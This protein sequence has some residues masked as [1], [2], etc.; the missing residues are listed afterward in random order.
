MQ[1]DVDVS[2]AALGRKFVK[3]FKSLR[4][5]QIF[6]R[7]Q[8]PTDGSSATAPVRL[9]SLMTYVNPKETVSRT[10]N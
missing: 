8:F 4:F 1:S 6:Y 7:I 9:F 3:F 2:T 10:I 5:R